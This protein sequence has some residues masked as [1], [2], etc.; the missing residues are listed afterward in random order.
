MRSVASAESSRR[1]ERK[2]MLIGDVWLVLSFPD[3]RPLGLR[4]RRQRLRL[5]P[6]SNGCKDFPHFPDGS[7]VSA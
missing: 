1:Y 2:I 4:Q 5:L 3:E 6:Q 7:V